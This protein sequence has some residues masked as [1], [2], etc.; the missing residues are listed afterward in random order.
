MA[1][2]TAPPP[3]IRLP[4]RAYVLGLL[5]VVYTFNFI[6]R[7]ILAILL[8]AIKAE[9]ALSDTVLGFLAGPAFALFYATL[10]VPIA[11]LADRWNR[12]NVIALALA[13]WSGMTALSG[14]AVNVTQLA[15]ARIGVGIGEAGCSPP[16]HSII[17]DLYGPQE[18]A[19]AMGIFTLGISAG[20]M[21]AYLAGGWVAQNVGWREAFF[22]VGVPG[23]ALAVVLRFTMDEPRRGLSEGRPDLSDRPPLAGVLRFLLARRSFLHLA[24]GSAL[25]AFNG[26]AVISWFPTFLGRTHGMDLSTIGLWLGLILGIAGGIGLAGGGWVLDRL[27]RR[28]AR[29]SLLGV[30]AALLVGWLFHVLVLLAP[31]E[32]SALALFVIPVMFS[33]VYLPA[34]FAQVQGLVPLRMR[35]VASALLLFILNSIGLGLGPQLAGMLSDALTPWLGAEA[36]RYSLLAVGALIL[37]WSAWHFARA[38][39][40]IERDLVRADGV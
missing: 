4:G 3:P 19:T 23:L 26:Y 30:T 21:L 35:A 12:R 22:I 34:A 32:H 38:G 11:L 36:L 6:D 16:A 31:N 24:A 20:I 18:R 9:F 15:L 13:I 39:R 25:A 28:G 27:G 29:R 33:Q 2:A 8:P 1:V 14:A 40:W 7:Q 10:G 17:A 5:T 37:P